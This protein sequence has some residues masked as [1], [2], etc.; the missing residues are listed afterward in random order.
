MKRAILRFVASLEDSQ[1]YHV[2][3]AVI[4][5]ICIVAICIGIY[6]DKYYKYAEIDPLMI[7]IRVGNKKSAEEISNLKSS[8]KNIFSNDV[9]AT[10]NAEELD[11]KKIYE[12]ADDVV[13]NAYVYQQE[14]DFYNIDANIPQLNID[15]ENAKK[16]NQ[17]I[18]ELYYKT[19][20]VKMRNIEGMTVYSVN[21]VAFVNK[22]YLSLVIKASLKEDNKPEKVTLKTY[23]Y[24][25]ANDSFITIEDLIKLKNETNESVQSIITKE[26]QIT[27]AN[28]KEVAKS[29]GTLYTRDLNSDIYKVENTENFFLTQDGYVYIVYAYGNTEDTNEMDIVIF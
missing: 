10:E 12:S 27:D 23:N 28:A 22:T 20:Y 6:V 4:I 18:H 19:A 17:E 5:A 1:R 26:I 8:F 15:A 16:I 13:Y 11:Y 25:I 7:G 2:F 21:Y 24:N 14:T 9:K 29:F 3:V